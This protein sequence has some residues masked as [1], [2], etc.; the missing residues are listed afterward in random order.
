MTY[1]LTQDEPPLEEP[2]GWEAEGLAQQLLEVAAPGDT[3]G[4][5]RRVVGQAEDDPD[6]KTE[7]AAIAMLEVAAETKADGVA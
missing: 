3:L 6:A 7:Y 1:D 2:I 5:N 4:E